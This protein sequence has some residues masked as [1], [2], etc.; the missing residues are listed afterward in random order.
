MREAVEGPH[1]EGSSTLLAAPR[2]TS[3]VRAWQALAEQHAT[4]LL[5]LDL[6]GCDGL[7]RSVRP[8]AA[9]ARL[10]CLEVLA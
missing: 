7:S 6:T 2:A 5:R 3:R 10:G 9:I 4:T 8:L 1:E